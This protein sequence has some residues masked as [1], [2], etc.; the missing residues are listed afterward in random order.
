MNRKKI[1]FTLMMT[2]LIASGYAE[3]QQG[4]YQVIPLPQ[5]IVNGN[6][7]SFVLNNSVTIVYP[8]KNTKMK[9]NAEFLSDYIKESTGKHL[10]VVAGT[11]GKKAIVLKIDVTINSKEAYRISV[12]EKNIT[13]SA[14]TEA[15]VFYGI[16]TLR[17]SI[18]I[19]SDGSDISM[20]EVQIND[21]PR[22]A[23][24][25]MM[26][27]V[28]R[29]FYPV[30]FIKK[31][32]DILALHNVNNFH[33]HLSEDQ[34]WR[35]EIKKYPNL[36]KVGS[37]RK[38]TVIGHNTG[39][40]D[41]IPYGGF[42]TQAQI[43]EI[44]AYAQDRFISIVPEIDLPGHMLAALAAYPELGCTGGPYQV[45]TQ[46]GVYD[47]VLCVGN[48]KTMRFIEDVLSEIIQL[49]PSKYI[50]IGGDE[51]PKVRWKTCPKC[52]ARI[53][54]EGIVADSK[55]SAEDRLQSYCI[56]RAEKFLNSKGRQIIGWDEILEG[57]LAPNA[58]VMSWRG[59]AGGIEAAKQ[60][61]DVIMTPNSHMYFDHY[62]SKDTKNEPIAIGGFLPVEQVYSYDPIPTELTVDEQKH[63]LG[64]Q[65]NLWTEY[66]P[67]TKQVEYMLLPRLAALC[68]VQWTMPALK[69]YQDFL[70]RI[71]RM[72]NIYNKNNYN[73]ATHVAEVK[74]ASGN[75]SSK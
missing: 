24:R 40:F 64:A 39:K 37:I 46:W 70:V 33:W 42:Y 60:K 75:I 72:I 59:V 19:V 27:D 57:G 2:G 18:P 41:G 35:I 10:G 1:L 36:T 50:H 69:N 17:K 23:Y 67:T 26:L 45:G 73:Y 43:K 5:Q 49:F 38:E 44:V 51:C 63:I 62:Q 9:R 54:A 15:G 71:P 31:Y 13:I 22:F 68:E 25:G 55:H 4:N 47:D 74:A 6:G 66:I 28:G 52:Q 32:I 14:S 8:A 58:T 56:S 29:H 16:Q 34:G 3:G 7:N 21:Y 20:P 48:D 30:A 61:H 65:A 11:S 12:T 53:K